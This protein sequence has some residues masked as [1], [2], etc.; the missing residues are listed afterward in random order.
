[1]TKQEVIKGLND[2]VQDRESFFSES[3]DDEVFRN[4]AKVL[5]EAIRFLG[6]I[7]DYY[8]TFGNNN[9]QPFKG[10]WLIVR[11]RSVGEAHKKFAIKYPAIDKI[12]SYSFFYKEEDFIKSG[13]MSKGNLGFFCHE[14]IEWKIYWSSI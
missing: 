13:M 1:M 14:I 11:A 5:E 4:D 3:G 2:L 6:G 8:F 7:N 12:Y 9:T 10:G